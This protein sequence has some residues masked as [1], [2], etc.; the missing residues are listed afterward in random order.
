MP[1]PEEASGDPG[2]HR[3]PNDALNTT[4]TM[5]NRS[6]YCGADESTRLARWGRP[7]G[8]SLDPRILSSC[9]LT[10]HPFL[11]ENRS[12]RRLHQ[13]LRLLPDEPAVYGTETLYGDWA[14]A[15][16][17]LA[18]DFT[19]DANMRAGSPPATEPPTTTPRRLKQT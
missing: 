1:S 8:R 16:L 5:P 18:Q 13:H 3:C 14:G 7:H 15:L 2:G 17:V 4:T 6:E 10:S 11:D 9:G 19:T 12:R